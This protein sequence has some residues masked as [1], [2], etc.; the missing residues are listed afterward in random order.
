LQGHFSITAA[1]S[2]LGKEIIEKTFLV[3]WPSVVNKILF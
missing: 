2:V 1:D 3:Q